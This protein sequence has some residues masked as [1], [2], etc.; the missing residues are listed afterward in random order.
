MWG[1]ERRIPNK[2][3]GDVVSRHAPGP[4]EEGG[5]PRARGGRCRIIENTGCNAMLGKGQA[6]WGCEKEGSSQRMTKKRK[7]IKKMNQ[8]AATSSLAF[9]SGKA[10]PAQI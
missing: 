1:V 10:Q 9:V 7:K 5:C 4:G 6:G 8:V 3:R 2:M